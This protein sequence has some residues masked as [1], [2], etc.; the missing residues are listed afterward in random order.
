MNELKSSILTYINHFGIYDYIAYAWL[1]LTFLIL[2]FLSLLLIKKST[3]LSIIMI[4]F[5]FLLLFI[6]PFALKYFLD[7][8]IRPVKIE[9]LRYKKLHFSN[10]LIVDSDIKNISKKPYTL[11]QIETKI[12]RYSK[13][14]FKT[15]INRLKP[16]KYMTILKRVELKAGETMSNRAVFYNFSYSYDINTSVIAECYGGKL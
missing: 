8:T 12:Y 1:I 11:C 13:S 5:S 3:K 2:I 6:G 15:F 7:K 4:L 14:K 10:T 9:H 16:I